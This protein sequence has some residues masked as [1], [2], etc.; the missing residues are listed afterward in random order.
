MWLE[1]G[2]EADLDLELR[3]SFGTETTFA[4]SLHCRLPLVIEPE[5]RDIKLS[6]NEKRSV[7]FRVKVPADAE[8]HPHRRHVLTALLTVNGKQHGPIA[9]ALLVVPQSNLN[10]SP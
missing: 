4:A 8:S 2:A 3:N 9:E 1:P 10:S 7:R 6:P 5:G